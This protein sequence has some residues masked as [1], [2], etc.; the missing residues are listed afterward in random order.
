M[1]DEGRTPLDLIRDIDA[2]KAAQRVYALSHDRF[3][4]A[5]QVY[6]AEGRQAEA[7]GA[8][9]YAV[10]TLRAYVAELADPDS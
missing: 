9:Y 3:A 6:R 8:H 2:R 7:E 1:S 10:I 4:E 5:E